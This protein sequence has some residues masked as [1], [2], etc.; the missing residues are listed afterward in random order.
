M[1]KLCKKLARYFRRYDNGFTNAH[2][3]KPIQIV[4]DS[5]ANVELK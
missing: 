4:F 1:K 2:S 5:P 3:S